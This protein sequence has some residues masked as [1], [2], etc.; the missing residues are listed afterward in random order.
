M[1]FRISLGFVLLLL[2][3]SHFLVLLLETGVLRATTGFKVVK[4]VLLLCLKFILFLLIKSLIYA[5]LVSSLTIY[6]IICYS[7]TF[8]KS[9]F[10]I[11]FYHLLIST[12]RITCIIKILIFIRARL[13]YFNEC[14]IITRHIILLKLT[15]ICNH[16]FKKLLLLM[17]IK[18]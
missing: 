10:T 2:L 5:S 16:K 17:I 3:T 7:S 8:G 1:H 11:F 12:S 15:R 14:R 9:Y 6:L 13:F 18:F 4:H